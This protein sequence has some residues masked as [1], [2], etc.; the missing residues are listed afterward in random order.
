M[1][2]GFLIGVRT[3]ASARVEGAGGAVIAA[4]DKN[5]GRQ[6][7]TRG[8]RDGN[9]MGGLRLEQIAGRGPLPRQEQSASLTGGFADGF[10]A[11]MF[12]WSRIVE[13]G[14]GPIVKWSER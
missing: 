1:G 11:M 14:N 3:L 6:A 12:L 8:R 2:L 10:P 13:S 4:E 7:S 5:T 9:D